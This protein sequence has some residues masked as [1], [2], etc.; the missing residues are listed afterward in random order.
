M[1][2][3]VA[4]LWRL[5]PQPAAEEFQRPHPLIFSRRSPFQHTDRGVEK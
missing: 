5:P 1:V 4:S 3:G 2:A